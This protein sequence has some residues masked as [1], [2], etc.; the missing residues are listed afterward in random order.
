MS[1]FRWALLIIL[2]V[3]PL[4]LGN[5]QFVSPEVDLASELLDSMTSSERVGQLF[6]VTLNGSAVTPS[7]QIIDLIVNYHVSGVLLKRGNDNF[8][9]QPETLNALQTLIGTLQVATKRR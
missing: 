2:L 9:D 4:N 1:K 3:V 7:D 8:A 6:I 5:A